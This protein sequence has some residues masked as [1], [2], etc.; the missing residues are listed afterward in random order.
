MLQGVACQRLSREQ[1]QTEVYGNCQ[2][3]F[4]LHEH[5]E[6]EKSGLRVYD[7]HVCV[8]SQR[9][10]PQNEGHFWPCRELSR[11]YGRGNL[12]LGRRTA[13]A[14]PVVQNQSCCCTNGADVT[15]ENREG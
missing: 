9:T 1:G 14:L 11:R 5:C 8:W 2:E 13:C 6:D 12:C 4:F 3:E 10:R 7:W 15:F